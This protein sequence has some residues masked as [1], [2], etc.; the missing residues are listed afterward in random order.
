MATVEFTKDDV[1][2][3]VVDANGN[4]VGKIVDTQ[5]GD[6]YVDPDPNIIDTVRANLGWDHRDDDDYILTGNGTDEHVE[7]V[8]DDEVRLRS[9]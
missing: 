3:T 9:F 6:A 2:K 5:G 7:A 4:P 1:G 8:T